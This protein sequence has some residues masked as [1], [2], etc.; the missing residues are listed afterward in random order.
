[1]HRERKGVCSL[2]R[3]RSVPDPLAERFCEKIPTSPLKCV[4]FSIYKDR[5]PHEEAF[6]M[7]QPLDHRAAQ[8]SFTDSSLI[9]DLQDGRSLS[10][11]LDW[12]PK[13]RD[14]SFDQRADH[15]LIGNGIGIHWESLGIDFSTGGLFLGSPPTQGGEDS[16]RKRI[17]YHVVPSD[18]K[19]HLKRQGDDRFTSFETKTEAIRAGVKEARSHEAGQL[20]IHKQNGQ[21]Q[22]ERTYGF[23]PPGRAG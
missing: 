1:M 21:F 15:R 4:G 18:G 20:I 5:D 8:V 12:Y 22:E 16:T 2:H 19:W 13:L 14:A 7:I 6:A 17:S 10:V 3:L 23:D 9:V 11:P